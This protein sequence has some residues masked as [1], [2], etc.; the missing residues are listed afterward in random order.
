MTFPSPLGPVSNPWR[1]GEVAPSPSCRR[2]PCH[3][4][5][6][7]CPCG[8]TLLPRPLL[9]IK[10]PSPPPRPLPPLPLGTRSPGWVSGRC[11]PKSRSAG[12]RGSGLHPLRG[13]RRSSRPAEQRRCRGCP[14]RGAFGWGSWRCVLPC[15][16][17]RLSLRRAVPVSPSAA[18]TPRGCPSCFPRVRLAVPPEAV[19]LSVCLSPLGCPPASV[20]RLAVPRPLAC[21]SLPRSVRGPAARRVPVVHHPPWSITPRGPSLPLRVPCPPAPCPP[22]SVSPSPHLSHR[23]L[24]PPSQHSPLSPPPAS[25]WP[26]APSWAWPEAAPL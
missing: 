26:S 24:F 20:P 2:Q 10:P 21:P 19:C 16:L 22:R 1:R 5:R 14:R 13:R 12:P 3:R 8:G 9:G 17:V 18:C 15:H 4:K 25:D 7:P 11:A 6:L 23:V